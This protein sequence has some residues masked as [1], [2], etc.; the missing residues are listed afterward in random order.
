[1]LKLG[2]EPISW[3]VVDEDAAHPE[4]PSRIRMHLPSPRI[5]SF[6][7]TATYQMPEE[8]AVSQASIAL[9]VPLLAPVDGELEEN[10]LRIA[11]V[12]GLTVQHFDETWRKLGGTDSSAF[13]CH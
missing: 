7:V 13:S 3:G 2:S 12:V 9:K 8:Q 1:M 6:D 10:V 11:D 4:K 5:D